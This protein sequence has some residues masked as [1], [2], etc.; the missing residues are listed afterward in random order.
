MA[1]AKRPATLGTSE[2]RTALPELVHEAVSRIRPAAYPSANAVEIR[3]RGIERSVSLV[4]TIDLDAA[5]RRIAELEEDLE[6]A[7]IAI[8]IAERLGTTSGERLSA[9]EFLDSIGMGLFV[10]QL[11]RS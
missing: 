11:Q 3:P 1:R 8:L 7:G 9:E 6:D 10:E 4:P 5:E 2:A